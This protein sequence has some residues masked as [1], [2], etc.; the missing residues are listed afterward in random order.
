[1]KLKQAIAIAAIAALA[2]PAFAADQSIDLSSMEA[3]F[4]YTAPI[5]DGGS[6]VITF[7]GLAAGTYD[8]LLTI[9]AQNISGLT[10]DL[11]GQAV[12]MTNYGSRVTLGYLESQ[13]LAPMLLTLMGTPNAQAQYSI[14]MS[15]SAVPEPGTYALLLAGLGAIGFVAKRRRVV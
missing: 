3:S 15:V 12:G 11:N 14:D 1:M 6:D 13:T 4:A 2:G 5:L 7:T 8:F 9:S 10:A